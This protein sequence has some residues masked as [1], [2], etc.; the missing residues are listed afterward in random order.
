MSNEEIVEIVRAHSSRPS[1]IIAAAI[2]DEAFS[3]NSSDNISV[4]VVNLK[5][6]RPN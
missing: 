5:Y 3:R 4:I 2:R 6:L 1:C